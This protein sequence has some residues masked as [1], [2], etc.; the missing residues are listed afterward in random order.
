MRYYMNVALIGKGNYFHYAKNATIC[1]YV[2]KQVK[3]NPHAI[4]VKIQNKKL[5]YLQLDKKSNQLAHFLLKQGLQPKSRV[6][7]Y[8]ESGLDTIISILAIL[9]TGGSY[10]PLDISYPLD[11][12]NFMLKDSKTSVLLTQE[13]TEGR[14][15]TENIA[16]FTISKYEKDIKKQPVSFIPLAKADDTAYII[17][18]SGSTGTPKGV[19]IH[20][21][22]V[23]NHMLWM[24]NEFQFERTDKIL[25]KTPLSFDPSVWEIF[26]SLYTGCQLI[27]A[28]ESAHMDPGLLVK[29]VMRYK[30]TT[31]QLVPSLLHAFLQQKNIKKCMS[32]IHVFSGGET[33]RTETKELFFKKLKCKL[34]NLYGPAEATIDVTSYTFDNSNFDR[35]TNVIGKPIYNTA[36]YV[37]TSS[38][39]LANIGEEGELYIGGDGL[40]SGYYNRAELTREKFIN[41]PFEP[42]KYQKVYKTGDIVRWVDENNL[43]YL[44]RTNDQIKINGVRIE[45]NEL[46]FHIL[47]HKAVSNCI[48]TKKT[49]SYGHDYVVCFLLAKKGLEI[50]IA[51]I[52]ENLKSMFPSFMLPKSYMILE[53]F[54]LTLNGK[55]DVANLPEP[56]SNMNQNNVSYYKNDMSHEENILLKIWKNILKCEY[57][58]VDD[59]FFDVGGHSLLTLKLID[60]IKKKFN[61]TIRIRD[62]FLFPSIRSQAKHI[63]ELKVKR[64]TSRVSPIITLQSLGNKTPFFIIHPIGG[65]VFWYSKL[66]KLLGEDRIIYAI[67]DPGI[68]LGRK[69]LNSIEEMAMFYALEIRKTQSQGPYL[70]GG[71]SFGATVAIEVA[72]ILQQ[73]GQKI[74]TI[75][76]FDGWGVYPQTLHN[77]DYFK[78]SMR[79]QH[80]DLKAEFAKHRVKNHEELFVIQRHRLQQLWKYHL[81]NIQHRIGLFKSKEILPIFKEIDAPLNHWDEF[82]KKEIISFLVPG[83]HE[84]MF[85]E[86]HVYE[87]AECVKQYFHDIKI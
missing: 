64:K 7:I 69:V 73:Q 17:Y 3:Q 54:P 36:L 30:I 65:T 28:P 19:K 35:K 44:G 45:P 46:M 32:L 77:D 2:D 6:A 86:P 61:I 47:S 56:S 48:V 75:P 26:L 70:I 24:K 59:N 67:Q 25:L 81:N 21:R 57:I 50:D 23:N 71:A 34:H 1:T 31:I 87:L 16:T 80:D 39:Q 22:A 53:T 84:T 14:L 15:A 82:T 66:A 76:I 58:H 8:M 18:T 52:K 42:D 49:D 11:R 51:V 41:N 33:L 55:I 10:I 5:S 13:K 40:S 37:V 12:L 78:E 72:N 20:H 68:D 29:L 79:R 60:N 83:N 9:K 62:I 38:G 85:Q 63:R 43:E 4:A 27:I 74:A